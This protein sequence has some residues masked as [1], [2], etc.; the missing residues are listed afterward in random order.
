MAEKFKK[1][2]EW[3]KAAL[4][5]ARNCN[6]FCTLYAFDLLTALLPTINAAPSCKILDVGC[7]AGSLALAYLRLFPGGV[8]G[9]HFTAT[10]ISSGMIE[11]AK[12]AVN[13]AKSA[14]CK[15]TFE[16]RIDDGTTLQSVQDQSVDV[17]VSAFAIFLI[18]DRDAVLRQVLR[19]LKKGG[20]LGMTAWTG[21]PN[22]NVFFAIFIYLFF[23]QLTVLF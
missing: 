23:L 13:T 18:P 4:E 8:D 1:P 10:D 17:V 3:D 19:V 5:Y 22:L 9:H 2:A 21:I 16:F 11:Q 20:S 12:E 6:P 7:G 15:T 14:N